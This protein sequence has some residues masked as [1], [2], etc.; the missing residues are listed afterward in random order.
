MKNIYKILIVVG[1]IVMFLILMFEIKTNTT[2]NKEDKLK[3]D[4]LTVLVNDIKEEQKTIENKIETINEEVKTID[5]NIS[6]IKIKREKTGKKYHEEITRVDTYTDVELDSF[7]T[8][9]YK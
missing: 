7:F 4:S 1:I 3:I 9:R 6:K 8:N 2:I 5:D